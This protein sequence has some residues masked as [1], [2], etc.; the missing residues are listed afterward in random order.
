LNPNVRE[1]IGIP[2]FPPW[3]GEIIPSQS[4]DMDDSEREKLVS[5]LGDMYKEIERLEKE[6]DSTKKVIKETE[7]IIETIQSDIHRLINDFY[8]L[9]FSQKFASNVNGTIQMLQDKKAETEIE[10]KIIDKVIEV[11]K[12][13]L[14]TLDGQ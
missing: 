3:I 14:H 13:R 6:S 5:R 10:R 12:E 8:K 2:S 7:G 1:T 11:F 9:S 4:S